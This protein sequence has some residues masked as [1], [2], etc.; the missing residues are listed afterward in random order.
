M[1]ID[2]LEIEIGILKI[3]ADETNLLEV[4]FLQN[5]DVL[6]VNRN[7]I[8]NNTV[9]QLKE[10]FDGDRKVFDLPLKLDGT[11]FQV[12]CWNA[13]IDIPYGE[14]RSY[15]DQAISIDNQKAVR[16]VG[17]ANNKNKIGI[18]IPCHRVIGKNGSLT[19][20]FSGIEHKKYLLDLEKK[21]T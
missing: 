18:I 10:Y 16:A 8:T 20:Y 15:Q 3:V 12:M 21:N 19:G 2:Y 9:R 14:T 11:P 13:L 4:A 17:G 1:Y 5:E 7:F 6:P